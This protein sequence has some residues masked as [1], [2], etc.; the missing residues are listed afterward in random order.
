MFT[1]SIVFNKQMSH[2][3]MCVHQKQG[4]L[5]FIG[6][7]VDASETNMDASYRELEEETGI[8]RDDVSLEFIRQEAV[9]ECTGDVWNMYITAGVLNKDSIELHQEKNP[10]KWIPITDTFTILNSFHQGSCY[11]Y[12]VLALQVLLGIKEGCK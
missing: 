6:G 10:L 12:M 9:T 2:V 5:N 7:K 11:T 8:T 1:L 3:L 4:A